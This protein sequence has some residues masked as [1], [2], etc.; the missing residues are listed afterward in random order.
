MGLN[1][2]EEEDEMDDFADTLIQQ[3]MDKYAKQKGVV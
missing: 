1:Y 3:E 2:D